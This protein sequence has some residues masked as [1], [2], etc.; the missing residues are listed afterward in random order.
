[1]KAAILSVAVAGLSACATA[2]ENIRPAYVPT[3][4]YA[5]QECGQIAAE[6]SR[7]LVRAEEVSDKQRRE[8]R[9]DQVALG[10]AVLVFAPAALFMIG[11]DQSAELATLKGQFHSLAVLGQER[12]CAG[13]PAVAV[14]TAAVASPVVAVPPG[15]ADG[16][17]R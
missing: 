12:Q 6:M 13:L 3:A 14:P 7:V 4:L 17:R 2:P 5:G 16:R 9:K 15:R 1:M 8:R 11:G 10:A